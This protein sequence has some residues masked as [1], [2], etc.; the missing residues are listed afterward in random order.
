MPGNNIQHISYF[1]DLLIDGTALALLHS[2]EY[3]SFMPI[4]L[5]RFNVYTTKLAIIEF[6]AILG[7]N[8]IP[9]N[10]DILL[11]LSQLYKVIDMDEKELLRASKIFSDLLSHN[12]NPD[13]IDVIHAAI[14]IE[15][16]LLI[17]TADVQRYNTLK[18]YG[19]AVISVN[20]FLEVAKNIMKGVIESMFQR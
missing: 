18:R 12:E 20:E 3:R 11:Y 14:S 5:T 2:D 1:T 13:I 8:Q 16:K 19:I 6:L 17:V 15:R 9:Y 4:I 7:Y 10:H